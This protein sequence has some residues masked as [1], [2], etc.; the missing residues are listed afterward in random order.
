MCLFNSLFRTSSKSAQT[1]FASSNRRHN[2]PVPLD[3]QKPAAKRAPLPAGFDATKAHTFLSPER[4]QSM[5][6]RSQESACLNDISPA[7]RQS[8]TAPLERTAA[9]SFSLNSPIQKRRT[10]SFDPLVT[11][12]CPINGTI[13]NQPHNLSFTSDNYS[14]TSKFTNAKITRPALS[15]NG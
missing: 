2:R 6:A 12:H 10:V 13:P 4:L 5:A 9:D 14:T 11:E 1:K 15:L 8:V 3:Q 7:L